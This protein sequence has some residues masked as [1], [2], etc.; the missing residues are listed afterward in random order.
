MN[1]AG[2]CFTAE[3]RFNGATQKAPGSGDKSHTP[4]EAQ[5][6]G[7]MLSPPRLEKS[8]Y[9]TQLLHLP[10]TPKAASHGR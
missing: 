5:L 3:W 8:L 1:E 10:G 2:H 4:A 7:F 9:Q 6:F